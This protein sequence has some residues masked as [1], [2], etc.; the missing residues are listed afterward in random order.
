MANLNTEIKKVIKPFYPDYLGFADL[1]NYQKQLIELGGPIVEGY[2][3]GISLGLNI[4]DSIVDFLPQRADINAACQ[5]RTHG[6]DI[7]NERLNMMASV[8]GSFL[9]GKGYR[10]LPIPAANR[11]NDEKGQPT[12]SHKMIAHIAGLG[13]I[14]K[15][16]L[17][18][19]PEHGPRVRW[20]SLLTD[21]PLENVD[22][23]LEQRCGDCVECVSI[24]PTQSIKGRNFVM[25]EPRET[26]FDFTRCDTYFEQMKKSL[27]Y[28]VCGM[29]L[30][31]CPHGQTKTKLAPKQPAQIKG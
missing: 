20:I 5:Y 3:C 25:G 18:V 21:A 30:Y 4:P 12:V 8:V 23:P 16:C 31:V 17:L 29:C 9:N 2:P 7:L 10:T 13:W 1:R 27:K 6:Y 15:S 19:T 11:T 28:P 26:R 24:C 14:G 22:S